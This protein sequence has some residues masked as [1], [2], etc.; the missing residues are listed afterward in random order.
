MS[1]LTSG[2]HFGQIADDYSLDRKLENKGVIDEYFTKDSLR[3]ALKECFALDVGKV[4][5]ILESTN[6]YHIVKVIERRAAVK[7]Q[8]D[9]IKPQLMS[10]LS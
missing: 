4:S 9:D 5:G 8:F 7:Q 10:K 6:G 2:E 3:P 1:R